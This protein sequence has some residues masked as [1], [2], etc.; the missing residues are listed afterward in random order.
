MKSFIRNQI[1]KKRRGGIDSV[2]V[3]L[4]L[5]LLV[6]A[7]IPALK[8]IANANAEASGNVRTDIVNVT[9]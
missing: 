3:T 1:R 8:S 7:C 2:I 6:L 5:V 4:V 9:K